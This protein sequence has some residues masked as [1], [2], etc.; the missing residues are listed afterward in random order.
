MRTMRPI[1][2]VLSIASVLALAACTSSKSVDSGTTWTVDKTTDL[3]SLT[4]AQGAQVVAPEGKSLTLSVDGTETPIAPGTFSGKVVLSITDQ[5]PVK[6]EGMGAS[7]VHL[8]R[9]A[10]YLDDKGVVDSKSVVATAGNYS[11]QSGVLSGV[12]IKSVGENFN[13][14][15]ATAGTQTVKGATIDFTGNGGNDF[16]GF[17]AAILSI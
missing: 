9:Q 6:F 8:F 5:F 7:V 13:G 2:Q 12:V 14:I 3:G 11:Y 1:L 15:V 16:A 17:G 4:I 10:L